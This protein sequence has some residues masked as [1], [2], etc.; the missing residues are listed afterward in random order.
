MLR[1]T[2][3]AIDDELD[4]AARGV[5]CGLAQGAE[6]GWIKVGQRT[7]ELARKARGLA[8]KTTVIAARDVDG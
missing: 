1:G 2:P 5:R 6:E 3:A 4:P 7:T 8:G